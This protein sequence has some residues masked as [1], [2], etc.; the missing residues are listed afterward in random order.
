MEIE[1]DFG[2]DGFKVK[3][4]L[5]KDGNAWCV[6]LGENLQVGIAGFGCTP[7]HAI[8]EFKRGFRNSRHIALR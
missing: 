1:I 8:T 4:I 5:S 2:N 3:A 6:L 7:I